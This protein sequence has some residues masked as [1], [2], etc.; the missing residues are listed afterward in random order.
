MKQEKIKAI[1]DQFVTDRQTIDKEKLRQY[2]FQ[3]LSDCHTEADYLINNPEN[4]N[5]LHQINDL[6]AQH[7]QP[8][9]RQLGLTAM[10]R[11]NQLHK[12]VESWINDNVDSPERFE[13]SIQAKATEISSGNQDY[14]YWAALTIRHD[15]LLAA[16]VI[17]E[18]A[19]AK[20]SSLI[21]TEPAEA[22]NSP[23]LKYFAEHTSPE[24]IFKAAEE[25]YQLRNQFH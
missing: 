21:H 19:L 4:K 22:V 25:I 17:F 11:I 5:H 14:D 9:I 6:L 10:E 3:S 8:E 7:Q 2:V 13:F 16:V 20:L 23:D 15:Q 24:R 1:I 18:E 12:E